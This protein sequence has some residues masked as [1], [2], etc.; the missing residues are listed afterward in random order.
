MRPAIIY[1]Y[2]RKPIRKDYLHEHIILV[3]AH[4]CFVLVKMNPSY[5]EYVEAQVHRN[6][7]LRGLAGF[8][9]SPYQSLD[10]ILVSCLDF[11]LGQDIKMT[12]RR[13]PLEEC[14]S[15]LTDA[16]E[17]PSKIHIRRILL[18]EDVNPYSVEKLGTLLD[19]NPLDLATY[20]STSFTGIDTAPPPPAMAMFPSRWATGDSLHLHYQRVIQL[21]LASDNPHH[22]YEFK[23]SGNVPRSV[24]HLTPLSGVQPG[25]IRSCCSILLKILNNQ[26][27]ICKFMRM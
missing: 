13:M 27:W 24:R 15:E 12:E 10:D 17:M 8:L 21:P 18:L 23:S 5:R 6:P 22:P 2:M 3:R 20:V 26:S 19:I 14:L 25:L 9:S 4:S 11:T 7:S 1:I 16:M